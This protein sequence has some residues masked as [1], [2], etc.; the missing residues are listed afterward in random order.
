M[1]DTGRIS[2]NI[3]S[4]KKKKMSSEQKSENVF[5]DQKLHFLGK[6][7]IL[8]G[9][10]ALRFEEP[11]IFSE[12]FIF[13]KNLGNL[14]SAFIFLKISDQILDLQETVF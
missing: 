1:S 8:L 2:K 5:P 3:W 10:P 11:A 7:L 13:Q 6:C 14:N 9:D 12:V 4:E